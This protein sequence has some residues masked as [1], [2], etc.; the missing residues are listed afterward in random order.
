MTRVNI[1]IKNAK[2]RV[3]KNPMYH[4]QYINKFLNE[5]DETYLMSKILQTTDS[6]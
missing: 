4:A 2:T 6:I 3:Y 1:N 5:Q